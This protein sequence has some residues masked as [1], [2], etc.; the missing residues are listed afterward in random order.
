MNVLG[1]SKRPQFLTHRANDAA[2]D[3]LAMSK[4]R[5]DSIMCCCSCQHTPS[6]WSTDVPETHQ[7]T[8]HGAS[9]KS[10]TKPAQSKASKAAQTA[11]QHSACRSHQTA[12]L[13]TP[14]IRKSSQA[15]AHAGVTTP[16]RTQPTGR[17]S[18]QHTCTHCLQGMVSGRCP[19]EVCVHPSPVFTHEGSRAQRVYC[20]PY[21]QGVAVA[22]VR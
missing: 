14:T 2:A 13:L 22:A 17:S 3:S 16:C 20:T 8:K 4:H 19:A 5:P 10:K 9:L 1:Q 15:T 12:R 6:T 7:Q 11:R 21:S 18:L